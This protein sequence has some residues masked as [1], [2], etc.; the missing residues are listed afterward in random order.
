MQI[1]QAILPIFVIILVVL[2]VT[3]ASQ[4][5]ASFRADVTQPVVEAVEVR[6]TRSAV[7]LH[8][9]AQFIEV[10]K[11]EA[12]PPKKEDPKTT[13]GKPADGKPADGKAAEKKTDDTQTD[14]QAG[15]QSG[16]SKPA[17]QTG[18]QSGEQTENQ[19]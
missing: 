14:G 2:I 13:D 4:N 11:S 7:D 15:Q 8:P 6:T 16:D 19:T 17:G 9:S 12:P 18:E 1:W 3:N 10:N 5:N